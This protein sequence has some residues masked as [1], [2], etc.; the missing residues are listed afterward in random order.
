MPVEFKDYYAILGVPRDASEQDI[1]TSFRKL[2]RKHHPD[3]A[4]DKKN[5]EE[6]FKEINEAYE[7]LGDP[8]KRKK[9]DKFGANWKSGA[10]F[11]PPPGW[12]GSAGPGAEG[13]Q[14]RE[15]HFSGTGFSDF[16]EQLFGRSGRGG[17][18]FGGTEFEGGDASG[19][20][21]GHDV[22]GDIMVTLDEVGRGSVRSVSL[23]HTNPSAGKAE[24]HT[25]KVR[26]PVGVHEGQTIR[27]S[28]K[29]GPGSNGEAA[30]D[31]YLHVLYAAH[32]DFRARGSDLYHELD[33]APWEAV[34]G[35]TASVPTLNGHVSVRIPPGTDNGQQLRVRGRGLPSRKAGEAGDLYVTVNVRLP[36]E[37][38]AE[39]REAW[40]K[41]GRVSHFRP[42]SHTS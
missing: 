28:G 20:T 10:G 14:A 39:E 8:D 24:T 15:F 27:I 18:G 36:R 40:E 4:K 31:L 35:T 21:R 6:K 16:F 12:E 32:P 5:A 41:L 3:V 23:Q 38:T 29:G 42:R 25:F 1:K 22:E 2:A 34:L 11:E 33:L 19:K 9:Y 26:I 37:L 30:G 17:F 13:P 7:V